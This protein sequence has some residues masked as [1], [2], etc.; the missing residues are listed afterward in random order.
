MNRPQTTKGPIIYRTKERGTKQNNGQTTHVTIPP[1]QHTSSD[2][3]NLRTAPHDEQ[4]AETHTSAPRENA[5][6]RQNPITHNNP[7]EHT[8]SEQ[9]RS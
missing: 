2:V 9:G 6:A 4:H 3:P 5:G 1:Q 7:E 8:R